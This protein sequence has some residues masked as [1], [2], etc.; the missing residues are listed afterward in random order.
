[1]N[2]QYHKEPRGGG[3]KY[4]T[5]FA[6]RKREKNL[7]TGFFIFLRFFVVATIASSIGSLK[8]SIKQHKNLNL[9][10]WTMKYKGI[11]SWRLHCI[12]VGFIS[13][14]I[15][16][17]CW[18]NGFCTWNRGSY[19]SKASSRQLILPCSR[20]LNTKSAWKKMPVL[21]Q[22]RKKCFRDIFIHKNDWPC[23]WEWRTLDV[24]AFLNDRVSYMWKKISQE[25]SKPIWEVDFKQWS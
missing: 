5:K 14:L 17:F 10:L 21:G 3:L 22:L 11:N 4:A 23:H 9:V 20:S 1:M 16:I 24:L 12:S 18:L 13:H 8:R 19:S 6:C 7:I 15:V 2:K 25:D